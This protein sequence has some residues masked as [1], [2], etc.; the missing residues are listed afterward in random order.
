MLELIK[1]RPLSLSKAMAS[2]GPTQDG[3]SPDFDKTAPS[4]RDGKG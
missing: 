4:L 3:R 1:A 2:S